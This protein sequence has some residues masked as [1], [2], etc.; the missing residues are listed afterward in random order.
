MK[1]ISLVLLL[2]A[3]NVYSANY[4][5]FTDGECFTFGEKLLFGNWIAIECFKTE[6]EARAKMESLQK[7][8][9]DE[10]RMKARKWNP[11]D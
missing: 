6:R 2:M 3:T 1:T 7:F 4:E 10:D 8:A 5:I 11:L 9:D